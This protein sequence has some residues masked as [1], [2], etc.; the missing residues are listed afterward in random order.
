MRYT[1]PPNPWINCRMVLASVSMTHSIT[2]LPA[3]IRNCDR[4]CRARHNGNFRNFAGPLERHRLGLYYLLFYDHIAQEAVCVFL[5][6]LLRHLRG[7]AALAKP[8]KCY[9]G[10]KTTR[11]G[12]CGALL[13]DGYACGSWNRAAVC[14]AASNRSRIGSR[15]ALFRESLCF[16][17]GRHLAWDGGV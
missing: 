4:K 15:D 3:E 2:T 8:P 16:W 17:R 6:E 7:P 14:R 11:L 5:R 1:S 10:L 9:L 13:G 12:F